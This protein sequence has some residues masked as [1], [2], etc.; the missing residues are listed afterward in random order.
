MSPKQQQLGG[1]D[2]IS[3]M[4]GNGFKFFLSCDINLPVRLKIESLEGSLSQLTENAPAGQLS[5]AGDSLQG[6]FDRKGSGVLSE[7]ELC[8]EAVLTL[9]GVPFGLPVRTRHASSGGA[10]KQHR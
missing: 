5:S 4:S 7:P 10:G 6:S 8:V 2:A 9:D 3:M 1:A